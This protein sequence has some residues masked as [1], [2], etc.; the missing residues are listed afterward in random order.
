MDT[1]E[2]NLCRGELRSHMQ[3]RN[4]FASSWAQ[5]VVACE[6]EDYMSK[7]WIAPTQTAIITVDLFRFAMLQG[8]NI[9]SHDDLALQRYV[10]LDFFLSFLHKKH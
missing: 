4:G 1:N 7:L 3:S 8:P 6:F 5:P 9:A 2:P 10:G